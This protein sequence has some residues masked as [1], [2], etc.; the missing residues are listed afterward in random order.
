MATCS[1]TETDV[2]A[3]VLPYTVFRFRW[4]QVDRTCTNTEDNKLTFVFNTIVRPVLSKYA[5]SLSGQQKGA[6]RYV[7]QGLGQLYTREQITLA[8]ISLPFM[9]KIQHENVA[10]QESENL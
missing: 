9:D 5:D 6:G 2:Y 7:G 10:F 1:C 3:Y 8:T 4:T